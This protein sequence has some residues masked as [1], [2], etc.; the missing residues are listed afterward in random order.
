MGCDE[1]LFSSGIMVDE[2]VIDFFVDFIV[3]WFGG[4]VQLGLQL[5]W[6]CLQ[7]GYCGFQYVVGQF[8]LV[9]MGCVYFVVV[10]GGEYYWQVVGGQDCQYYVWY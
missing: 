1:C 5:C 6:W 8:L 9:G 4:W 2:G 3:G 7:G 10:C